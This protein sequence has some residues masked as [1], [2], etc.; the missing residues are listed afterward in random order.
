MTMPATPASVDAALADATALPEV[1]PAWANRLRRE[2]R[3]RFVRAGFPAADD[4]AWR[5][6]PLR[7]LRDANFSLAS[8]GTPDVPEA[9]PGMDLPRFEIRNGR[10]ASPP[11]SRSG[12]DVRSLASVLREDPGSIESHLGALADTARHPFAALNTAY[13]QDGGVVRVAAG[14]RAG[15]HL[16]LAGPGSR[17]VYPRLVVLVA[18]GAEVVLVEDY[19]GGGG[20]TGSVNEVV[21]GRGASL[22]HIRL[23]RSGEANVHLGLLAVRQERDSRYTS[24]VVALGGKLSRLDLDVVLVGEGAECVLNGLYLPM[25]KQHMDHHTWVS[26]DAP[27]TTSREL[28]KGVLAGKSSAVFN[29]RIVIREGAAGVDAGQTNRNL[30]LSAQALVNTN[31]ELEIFADDVKAQHGATIGQLEEEP[32]FYLRSR[33]LDD[34]T[35]RELLIEAF[36]GEMIGKVGL[37]PV[38]RMLRAELAGRF[39]G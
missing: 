9:F 24:H 31:P 26:H 17:A 20:F 11:V 13:L 14:A 25:G 2:N 36:A 16:T 37:E 39:Q 28:Y 10:F 22:R 19:V 21:L 6:T 12:L 35:A 23:D 29:G 3:E 8:D 30:L 27:H 34:R 38:E 7:T 5:F 33:G 18:D 32:L 4:E 1:A 15:V